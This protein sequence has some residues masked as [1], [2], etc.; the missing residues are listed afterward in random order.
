MNML[1]GFVPFA[2]F[3]VLEHLAGLVPSLLVAAAA[4]LL[5]LLRDVVRRRTPK[6]LEVGSFVLFGGLGLY[7]AW[8]RPGWSLFEVRL[9]VDA[10]L[11]LMVLGSIAIGRPFTLAY[12]RERASPDSWQRPAFRRTCRDIALAWAAAFAVLV[13]ADACMAW[14]PQ[15]PLRVA[16]LVSVAALFAAAKYTMSRAGRRPSDD[17]VADAG[18]A[19]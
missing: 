9:Y 17:A 4:S 15:V 19:T 12:A 18:S 10:G 11:L 5:I 1:L 14:L 8:S 3:A 7:A 13:G 16:I 6:P 2:A